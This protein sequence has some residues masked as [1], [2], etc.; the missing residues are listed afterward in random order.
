MD[1]VMKEEKKLPPVVWAFVPLL[2]LIVLLVCVISAFGSDALSGASQIVLLV[3]AACCILIGFVL[4]TMHWDDFE[5]AVNENVS[6]VSQAILILLLIGAVGGSWM[7]SG[8]VPTMIYYGMQIIN[9]HCFL[10][11]SCLICAVVSAVRGLPS[12]QSASLCWA[13]A[14]HRDS[15]K[16]GLPAP[17]F[18][19]PT[20]ETKSRR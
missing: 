12:P 20:S 16:D 9:P 6:S 15:A 10:V 11:S 8:I 5:R 1:D 13:S 4:K 14:R 17:L 2:I 7:V 19:V 18:R 3:T